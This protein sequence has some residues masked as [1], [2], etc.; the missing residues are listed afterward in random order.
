MITATNTKKN[1]IESKINEIGQSSI[2]YK[3]LQHT[4]TTTLNL[5]LYLTYP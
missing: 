4:N 2:T 1:D 3:S 5:S